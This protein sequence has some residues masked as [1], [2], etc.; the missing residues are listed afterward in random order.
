M[1]GILNPD[2]Y[3][4]RHRVSDNLVTGCLCWAPVLYLLGETGQKGVVSQ[5]DRSTGTDKLKF[6]ALQPAD[7]ETEHEPIHLLDLRSTEQAVILR[8]KQRPVV[9]IGTSP[10]DEML[11]APVYSFRSEDT[12]FC[13]EVKA[14]HY[15]QDFYLPPASVHRKFIG[16]YIPLDRLQA[17]AKPWVSRMPL[18]LSDSAYGLLR[19]WL[20][21]YLG[22]PVE[23]VDP[24]LAEYRSDALTALAS[25]GT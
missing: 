10:P 3:F 18:R 7:F 19:S 23:D 13:E 8:A 6:R 24:M 5:Y 16:G 25:L 4:E 2:D 14:Y 11:V 12:R 21:I 9:V 22:E 17:V 15:P 20:R 1:I